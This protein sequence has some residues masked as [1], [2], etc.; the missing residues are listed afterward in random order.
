MAINIPNPYGY[1]EYTP[2][3]A[4]IKNVAKKLDNTIFQTLCLKKSLGYHIDRIKRPETFKDS[5]KS[6]K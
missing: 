6:E 4:V 3:N 5:N 1:K 2:K